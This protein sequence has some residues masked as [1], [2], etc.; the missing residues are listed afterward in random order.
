MLHPAVGELVTAL[1][2]IGPAGDGVDWAAVAAD[3]GVEF[4]GDFKDFTS[5]FGAGTIDN[6]IVVGTPVGDAPRPGPVRLRDLTPDRQANEAPSGPGRL[7]WWGGSGDAADFYWEVTGGAPETWPVLVRSAE[8][9]FTGF[10]CGMAEF[11]LRMLGPRE[12]RPL[13]S[14]R[15]YG[16]PDSRFLHWREEAALPVTADPWEYLDELYERNELE[17]G[18]PE[19]GLVVFDDL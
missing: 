1:P 18:L 14:P 10:D 3:W 6:F 17:E 12:R 19:G 11:L 9:G 8:G 7:I 5:V 2:T 15:L 16:A 4:P 13:E